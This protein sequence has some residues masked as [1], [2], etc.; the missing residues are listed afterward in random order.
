M[1]GEEEKLYHLIDAFIELQDDLKRLREAHPSLFAAL[2][3]EVLAEFATWCGK[4]APEIRAELLDA[5]AKAA[6]A[7]RAVLG[8]MLHATFE[9]KAQEIAAEAIAARARV[10]AEV[11]TV[12]ASLAGAAEESIALRAKFDAT[13]QE[14]REYA[15][16]LSERVRHE[17]AAAPATGSSTN[18]ATAFVGRWTKELALK[19]GDVFTFRGS[20][21]VTLRDSTGILPTQEEQKGDNPRYVL[22]AAC[23]AP[24]PAG[25]S[26]TGLPDQ[27][28]ENGK[29][30]KTNGT[31]ASWAAITGGG[32]LLASNNLSDVA[33]A[34]TAFGNIK[35][36]ATEAATGV[37][38]LATSAETDAGKAVQASDTR[39]ANERVPTAA[40]IAAKVHA[41]DA[42]TPIADDDEFGLADSA[43]TYGLKKS[44]WSVVKSTLKT[45]FD[46]LYLAI[47]GTAADVN[48]AGTTIAG[49]LS[50]KAATSQKLDDFG[51]PDDNTDLD[52]STSRHGLALKVTA[53]ASGMRNVHCVDN[54]ETARKDA[55]LFD[56]TL[57][58]ALGVAAAGTSLS[59][60][61]RDHVHTMPTKANVGLTNVT[62]DVQTKAAIVPNTAPAAGE[63]L[64]G[65]AGGTAYAK[66]A[67]SSDATLASTGALTIAAGAV[68]N[69]KLATAAKTF[70]IGQTW[71]GG[72]SA[73]ATGKGKGF[74][75]CP[76]AATIVAWTM[77]ADAGTPVVK[78]WKIAAG[79]AKPTAT[80]SINT[81][82]VGLSSG[83]SVRS[84][85]LTDFTTADVA[86]NDIIAFNLESNT[87]DAKEITFALEL[88][89]A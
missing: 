49:A 3:A 25:T 46:G 29:F 71:D 30:L 72:G 7:N 84:T 66:A 83:T 86:A 50:G 58:E 79:T 28:G 54:T 45:Y 65:N 82:G 31:V 35:Q 89:R 21:Y 24:G 1:K 76:V 18:L 43:A 73:I 61:R 17:F 39:L 15:E 8:E 5:N 26:G 40:G 16:G 12:K 80:D 23:G 37:V 34:A 75:V 57:P 11:E 87:G 59:A 68:S 32:D 85:T 4:F 78:T 42:K 13:A 2:K 22:L 52:A 48:P 47:G 6:E 56:A 9:Q 51:T 69:A 19:V 81:S 64:V 36:A 63:I 62:D 77:T 10:S 41:A 88:T 70:K 27:S 44:L 60:A 20:S 53:P 38:E 33:D 55:A 14:L 74:I 67:V